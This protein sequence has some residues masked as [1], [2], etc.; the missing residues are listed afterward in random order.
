MSI[1]WN[2]NNTQNAG[3]LNLVWGPGMAYELYLYIF[4]NTNVKIHLFITD[5]NGHQK[6]QQLF[7]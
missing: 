6:A 4:M 3:L 1:K 7:W 2:G 5:S